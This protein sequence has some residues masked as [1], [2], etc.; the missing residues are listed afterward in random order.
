MEAKPDHAHQPRAV[1]A[2]AVSQL[3]SSDAQP[4]AA[5]A[6]AMVPQPAHT[7]QQRT[8]SNNALAAGSAQKLGHPRSRQASP[9]SRSSTAAVPGSMRSGPG[10]MNSRSS[11]SRQRT[12]PRSRSQSPR[13]SRAP[14][15]R[16]RG[17]P[18]PK[19]EYRSAV[20]TEAANKSLTGRRQSGSPRGREPHSRAQRRERTPPKQ[21][22]PGCTPQREAPC[23]SGGHRARQQRHGRCASPRSRDNSP[24]QRR[25][26]GR[27]L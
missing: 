15:H 7:D 5:A 16:S 11:S 21:H 8:A 1:A 22:R 12:P 2:A 23:S 27:C 24:L 4:D 6:A 9:D 19:G 17:S 18:S 26:A 25:R 3:P 14:L 10:G 13:R 20:R